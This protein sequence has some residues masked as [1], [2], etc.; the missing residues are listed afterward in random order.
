[1]GYV[2]NLILALFFHEII[3]QLIPINHGKQGQYFLN[4]MCRDGENGQL[5]F[6]KIYFIK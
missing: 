1:M 6:F 3:M 4:I 5:G 2:E